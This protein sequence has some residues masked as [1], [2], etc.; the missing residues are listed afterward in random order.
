M[1]KF[2]ATFPLLACAT[3]LALASAATPAAAT[4]SELQGYSTKV[5]VIE[6][7]P[8]PAKLAAAPPPAPQHRPRSGEGDTPTLEYTSAE[9]KTFSGV[10]VPRRPRAM[11]RPLP[12]VK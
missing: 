1:T 6:D 5:D 7:L 8:A 11:P 10:Q 3:A 4:F 9:P 12:T 2:R